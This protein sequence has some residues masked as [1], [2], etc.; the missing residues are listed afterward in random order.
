MDIK[1]IQWKHSELGADGYIN[2]KRVCTIRPNRTVAGGHDLLFYGNL[3]GPV[4]WRETVG[5][6]KLLAQ[7]RLRTK[8][9]SFNRSYCFDPDV[10]GR[11]S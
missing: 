8:V 7:R 6:A 1:R 11:L 2:D 10:I 5:E 9:N 4:E 3:S